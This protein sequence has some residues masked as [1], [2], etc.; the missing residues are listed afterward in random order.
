MKNMWLR[1]HVDMAGWYT[2]LSDYL[3]Y[4]VD[5][6]NQSIFGLFFVL[7]AACLKRND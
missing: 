3:H 7:L 4:S 5:W 2:F 1:F 6:V